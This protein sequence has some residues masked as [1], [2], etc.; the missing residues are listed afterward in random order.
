[1]VVLSNN[2]GCIVARSS[3]A[4]ALG[5]P[6]GAPLFQVKNI[7]AQNNVHVF[8]SNFSL[9]GDISARVMQVLE[10]ISP[11][12]EVYSIDEAFI[13]CKGLADLT[14]FGQHLRH[15]VLQWVGIPTS[16]GVA[17]TKTLAKL[18]NDRA[19][20]DPQH[21]G[22]CLLDSE[23]KIDTVLQQVKVGDIWGV[24]RSIATQLN[25]SG[26]FTGYE[27]KKAD[28]S[29]MR[30]RFTVVGERLWRELNG[31]ACSEVSEQ[32]TPKKSIQVTRSFATLISDYD[33]LR[34]AVARYA[35]RA[36]EKLRRS[37]QRVTLITVYI[38]TNRFRANE[39]AYANSATVTLATPAFDDVTLIH[40]ACLALAK[41]YRPEFRYHKAGVILSDFSPYEQRQLSLLT[42]ATSPQQEAKVRALSEAIDGLNSRFGRSTI[43]NG[44]CGLSA[45]W[46]DRKDKKSNRYTTDWNELPLVK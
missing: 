1:M 33:M 14:G 42:P 30:R 38:R 16:V 35:S 34:Q 37:Q 4:K 43:V 22:V 6:M 7:V 21:K 39:P 10:E 13:N 24:G 3:E 44:A 17:P 29:W 2:D 18:A 12:I 46:L 19:K 41:I 23:A 9:Y 36:G 20:K 31:M 45:A 32:V 26:I 40:S 11:E 8:S 25:Q 5:I 28:P 15:T 27:L